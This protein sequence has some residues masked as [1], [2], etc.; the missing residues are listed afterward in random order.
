MSPEEAV[1]THR[2]VRGRLLLPV[3][4][5]T[6]NLAQHAWN[7]PAEAVTSAAAKLG[8]ALVI[9]KIGECVDPAAPAQGEPWWR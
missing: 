1:L 2:D 9:P 7:Q 8:V 5:G 4:W 6:F 3:H